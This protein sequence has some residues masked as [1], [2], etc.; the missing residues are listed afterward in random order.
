M[1]GVPIG[2]FP[3]DP[4]NLLWDLQVL[5]LNPRSICDLSEGC[6]QPTGFAQGPAPAGSASSQSVGPRSA[7]AGFLQS[8]LQAAIGQRMDQI[9]VGHSSGYRSRAAVIAILVGFGTEAHVWD[10]GALQSTLDKLSQQ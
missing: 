5:R 9:T 7:L 8:T 4:I 3:W 1:V 10:Q 6:P 2:T